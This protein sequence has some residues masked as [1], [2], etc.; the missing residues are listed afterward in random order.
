MLNTK[1]QNGV[2]KFWMSMFVS[3]EN[4]MKIVRKHRDILYVTN[5]HILYVTNGHIL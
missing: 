4:D 5:G 3:G 1:I 2:Y